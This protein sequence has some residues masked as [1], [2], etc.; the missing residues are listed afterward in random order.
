MVAPLPGH[1]LSRLSFLAGNPWS[2]RLPSLARRPDDAV[3]PADPSPA[4]LSWKFSTMT[5][6]VSRSVNQPG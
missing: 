2:F 1:S 4:W 5:M 6:M 3:V